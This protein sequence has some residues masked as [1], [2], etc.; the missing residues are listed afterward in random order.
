MG[1]LLLYSEGDEAIRE[2]GFKML[3]KAVKKITL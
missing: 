3:Q 2:E 1:I